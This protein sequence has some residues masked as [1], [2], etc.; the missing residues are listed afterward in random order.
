MIEY[1]ADFLVKKITTA[2]TF[3]FQ[4]RLLYLANAMVDQ[5]IGLEEIDDGE[6]RIWFNGILLATFD[7]RDYIIR[8]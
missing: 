3:R 4:D 6:W 8:G 2:G 1:P 7:E 5:P